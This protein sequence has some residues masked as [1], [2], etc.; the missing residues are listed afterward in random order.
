MPLLDIILIGAAIVFAWAGWRKG[1]VAG[2]L[3]LVGFL[4]GG[5]LGA[6]VLPSAAEAFTQN[7]FVKVIIVLVGIIACA[8][9]GQLLATILGSRIRSALT[10]KPIRYVDNAAGALLNV[11]ALAL[12]VW[13]I[14][15]V[16][17]V[18][19]SST[20]TNQVNSSQVLITLD[21]LMPAQVRNVFSGVRNLVSQTGVP[22]VF[23]G[24]SQVTGPQVPPPDDGIT[25]DVADAVRGS[26]VRVSGSTPECDGG[27]SGSGFVIAPEIV[28]TNAHVVAGVERPLVRL[29]ASDSSLPGTVIHFDPNLDIALI[30]VP[31]LRQPALPLL[32]AKAATGD[33]AVVAGFPESGP[34]VAQAARVRALMD[35]V[36]D[37]IYGQAGVERE[38]Y[39]LRTS[40]RPGN[41]GGPLLDRDGR[42]MGMVFGAD[43]GEEQTAYAISSRHLRDAIDGSGSGPVGTGTCRLPD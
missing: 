3:S 2:V 1:F 31:G 32:N 12:V 37:D 28:A 25:T 7:E 43:K 10:W 35:A 16:A 40:V 22:R 24:I 19:P 18:V 20:V 8:V 9:I 34:F 5:I 15:M 39:V 23:A 33:D 42:V 11:I 38:I 41:S 29:R 26:I 6:L 30:G 27:V 13:I 4:G 36:G 14:A 21:S 17:S